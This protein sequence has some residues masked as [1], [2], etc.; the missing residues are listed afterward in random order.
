ML[1]LLVENL[2]HHELV[3]LDLFS[4]EVLGDTNKVVHWW[5]VEVTGNGTCPKLMLFHT[6]TKVGWSTI[7]SFR[8][9]PR[10]D[11]LDDTSMIPCSHRFIHP[12]FVTNLMCVCRLQVLRS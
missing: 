10:Q 5:D 7:Q 2:G 1:E 4:I 8:E 12:C 6:L 9:R 3:K 11:H